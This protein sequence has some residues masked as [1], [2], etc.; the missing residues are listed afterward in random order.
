MTV[1]V[2]VTMRVEVR[3]KVRVRRLFLTCLHPH[4]LTNSLPCTSTNFTYLT[5]L[6]CR[7][8]GELTY[9][10]THIYY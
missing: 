1:R 4:F 10:Y 7:G 8:A 9:C 3:V 5:G 2:M 6:R